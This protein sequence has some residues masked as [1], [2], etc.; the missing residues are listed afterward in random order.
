MPAINIA[1]E[2]HS[3]GDTNNTHWYLDHPQLEGVFYG[4]ESQAKQRMRSAVQ[5]QITAALT[6]KA[7]YR[8]MYIGCTNGTVLHVRYKYAWGY[9]IVGPNRKHSSGVTGMADYDEA[10]A[11]AR[12]H[13]ESYG[14]ISWEC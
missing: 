7:N 11:S 9:E 10:L 12:R 1:F 4:S 13:A 6:A 5:E 2:Y 3:N 8:E 14:G